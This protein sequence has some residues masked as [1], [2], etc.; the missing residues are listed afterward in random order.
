M[1]FHVFNIDQK[2]ETEVYLYG[3]PP[4][5]SSGIQV[6]R[7]CNIVSPVY[8][9]PTPG[10]EESLILEIKSFTSEVK[11]M[12]RVKRRN[13]FHKSVARELELLKLTFNK[14]ISFES[15]D[16]EH[17]EMILTEFQNPVENLVISK[18][19]MGPGIVE[20]RNVS[21]CTVQ[22]NDVS[23]VRNAKFPEL[24]MASIAVESA[25][26]CIS[27]FA[28]YNRKKECYT[29][30]AIGKAQPA[31]YKS[32]DGPKEV[33][34]FINETIRKD[35]PDFVV[36][37]N[38]HA[39]SKLSLRDRIVCDVFSFAQGTVK[40]RD[41]SIQELCSLY[42][43]NRTKGLEGDAKALV[44]IAESMN[45]LSLAKEMAEISGYLLNRCL[46]NCRAERIEYTLMHELYAG[47]YLFPPVTPKM[48]VKYSGG[49]VLDPV[50]GFYED[51]VL[52]LDF[53]SLY[54]SIIQEFNVCFSTVG[55]SRFYITED[56]AEDVL[57]NPEIVSS[58]ADRH[59]DTFLPRILRSLVRRRRSVKEL[60]RSAKSPEERMALDIRQRAL[61]L[62]ANSI[63]GCLGFTG[64][65]FCNFEMA[66][67][68]TAKGR[69]LLNETKIAAEQLGMKV[70]YGDTDS[71]MIHTR[72]PGTK[73][74][75][76]R[77]V[78]SAKA[79]VSKINSRYSS[80][81]IELEKVFKKLL[82]YTKKKYAALVFD[83]NGSCIE[84]KGIDIVRRDFCSASTD[85]SRSVL[86]VMLEDRE[87]YRS[88]VKTTSIAV[89]NPFDGCSAKTG[90]GVGINLLED[91]DEAG[92]KA[93]CSA[94]KKNN[95]ME[96]AEK[97]YGICSDFYST[98]FARPVEDFIISSV[99]SRDISAYT[100]ATNLPHVNLALRLRASK[101]IT[102]HQDDV[103]SYVIGEG[104]G[105]ISYR[106]YHPD[107]KVKIDYQYYIK[108]QLLPSLYRLV[109]LLSFVHTEKIGMIFEVKD[110]VPRTVQSTMTFVLPCCQ[111]V[112]GPASQCSRCGAV[113]P[114]EFYIEK[115]S[116][117]LY[118]AVT[119][120]Y[121]E[122]G[123]CI[124]CGI[125]YSNHLVR[126]F[127]CQK[128]LVFDFKNLEFDNCL[129]SIESSFQNYNIP[130]ISMLV[131]SYSE[132]SSYRRIGMARY[133]GKELEKGTGAP[134]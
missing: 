66:A 116:T 121:K 90:R 134:M 61:K 122:K 22:Y 106:A 53:N 87:E 34:A 70:I 60:L 130:E 27:K 20:L 64:S 8:F 105:P 36:Y 17:C 28:Y 79:L 41:Y 5:S 80:I 112:Q 76:G 77:A 100:N 96:T 113:I 94:L 10:N 108:N 47:G 103:V 117:K 99:L 42:R 39:K 58:V 65:R 107:E 38:L 6:L 46:G 93:R 31:G 16:S 86:N 131:S 75:Y 83:M 2:S 89:N 9:L 125:V 132:V 37:H 102:Y 68:I 13:I 63:Y 15:F 12:E 73:E 85:L 1:L 30:G 123:R 97:I 120:L 40:G 115:V 111:H 92:D 126:C 24:Q 88:D 43:I 104:D 49:L 50:Q 21:K 26:G 74:Y 101:N 19:I 110:V 114:D 118:Q 69:E 18:G 14:R 23:F 59:A 72:Y 4:E 25:G 124:D 95:T 133:F 35:N 48:N 84:T 82:L 51:I 33:L 78:D 7:V 52:L 57:N 91:S 71:I 119:S 67:F 56:N 55:S 127:E 11:E 54:P 62:T 98:L 29:C 129:C 3:R 81:G 32:L 128:D 109:S 45:A 44:D